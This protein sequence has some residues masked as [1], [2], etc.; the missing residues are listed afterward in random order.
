[1]LPQGVLAVLQVAVR[2]HH[3]ADVVDAEVGMHRQRG[4]CTAQGV[5]TLGGA[6]AALV[7]AHA[8][9]AGEADEFDGGA[10]GGAALVA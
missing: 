5:R 1:M 3:G 7:A 2:D 9:V 8:L 4:E 6:H 10:L